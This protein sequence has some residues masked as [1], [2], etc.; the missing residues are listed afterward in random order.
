MS[1]IAVDQLHSPPPP[2][3]PS[4]K[5]LQHDLPSLAPPKGAMASSF[6][7]TS[8]FKSPT[9]STYVWVALHLQSSIKSFWH[10]RTLLTCIC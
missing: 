7:W 9:R 4:P 10:P 1:H 2:H 5:E 3:P 8:L 6:S